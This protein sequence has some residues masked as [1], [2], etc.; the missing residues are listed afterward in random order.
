MHF[1]SVISLVL[2][3]L[4]VLGVFIEIPFVSNW[5]F[6]I[7]LAA[8]VII[9]SSGTIVTLGAADGLRHVD[10]HERSPEGRTLGDPCLG[11]AFLSALSIDRTAPI[12][13]L[14]SDDSA[15]PLKE[16]SA[17]SA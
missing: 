7:L 5:P 14:F 3:L 9:Y 8:Y 17:T 6:W 4:A 10:R 16:T 13:W 15:L 2:A 12:P 11:P 1:S